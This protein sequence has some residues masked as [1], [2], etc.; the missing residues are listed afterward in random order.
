MTHI[1]KYTVGEYGIHTQRGKKNYTFYSEVQTEENMQFDAV[2]VTDIC[3]W[4]KSN[5]DNVKSTSLNNS[6][7]DSYHSIS[8]NNVF[9]RLYLNV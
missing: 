7:T 6:I 9:V 1:A 8:P 3:I 2:T 4:S 5:P